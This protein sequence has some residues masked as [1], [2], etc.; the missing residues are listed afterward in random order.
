MDP[1][2]DHNSSS[3]N[4]GR[5]SDEGEGVEDEYYFNATKGRGARRQR[6]K[7]EAIYGVFGDEEVDHERVPQGGGLGFV[8]FVKSET[9]QQ[10]DKDEETGVQEPKAVVW[11]SQGEKD[12]AVTAA[13]SSIGTFEAHTKGI[14]AKLLSKMG[15]KQGQGL[16]KDGKGLAEPLEAKL[17]P[18]RQGMGFGSAGSLLSHLCLRWP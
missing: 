17:R 8:S 14:G 5:S 2:S 13:G 11:D 9:V 3:S 18:K 15:W 7:E 1:F 4:S 10:G 12:A 16:G 6:R